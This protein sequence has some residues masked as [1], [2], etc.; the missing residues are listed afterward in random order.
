VKKEKKLDKRSLKTIRSLVFISLFFTSVG[1]SAQENL[2]EKVREL[3]RRL[4]RL[5]ENQGEAT[6]RALDTN[7]SIHSFINSNL[8]L[9]GFFEAAATQIDGP[10]TDAQASANSF[11]MGLNFAAEFRDSFRFVSQF[12]TAAGFPLQNPHDDPRGTPSRRQF[13]GYTLGS[14]VAQAYV[15]YNH[16]PLL[17]VQAGLGYVPFGHAFQQRELVLFKRRLGPQMINSSVSNAVG[18]ASPLWT[19]VHIYGRFENQMGYNLYTFTPI[20][21]PD[22]LGLGARWFWPLNTYLTVGVSAQEGEENNNSFYAGG[23]DADLEFKSFG[24]TAEYA[25][26]QLPGGETLARSYY[27]EPYLYLKGRAL[28]VFLVGDYLDSPLNTTGTLAGPVAD[29]YKK[30]I[31]GAGLNWLPISYTRFRLSFLWH[32]YDEDSLV[33]RDQRRDYQSVDLSVGIAF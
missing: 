3:Q 20:T 24:L 15:E 31:Y 25:H 10:D 2:E 9:G 28:L 4:E 17:N 23:L 22:S 13:S 5:E 32:D 8:L 12:L 21:E 33:N 19:G 29:P 6:L 16:S 1:A 26:N 27:V 14:L 11:I 18:V 7:R 30:W